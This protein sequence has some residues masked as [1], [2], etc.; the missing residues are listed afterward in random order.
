MGRSPGGD[1]KIHGMPDGKGYLGAVH[2]ATDWT[3]GC[4]AITNEQMD[5]L[6]YHVEVG[7]PIKIVP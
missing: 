2:T 6:F 1:I 4:I 7:T 5:E 3:L